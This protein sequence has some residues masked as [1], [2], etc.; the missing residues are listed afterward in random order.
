MTYDSKDS[1]GNQLAALNHTPPEIA[2]LRDEL[3]N[4]PQ[5]QAE[6]MAA[7]DFNECIAIIA[8]KCQIILD[9]EY[10]KE[11]V[12]KLCGILVT[13]LQKE[14]ILIIPAGTGVLK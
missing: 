2:A 11:E 12:L 10:T 1:L 14:S 7:E 8:A 13:K 5:L 3:V 9:G 6:C 4:H